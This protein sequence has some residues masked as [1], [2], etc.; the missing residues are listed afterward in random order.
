MYI[1]LYLYWYTQA[2]TP[3]AGSLQFDPQALVIAL[4]ILA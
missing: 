2:A 3:I 1:C 4:S